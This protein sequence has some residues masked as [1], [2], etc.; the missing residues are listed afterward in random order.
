MEAHFAPW[1]STISC[2]ALCSKF[3][4]WVIIGLKLE[5]QRE[6]LVILIQEHLINRET[7]WIELHKNNYGLFFILRPEEHFWLSPKNHFLV[8]IDLF[9][10]VNIILKVGIAMCVQWGFWWSKISFLKIFQFAGS[11]FIIL[12]LP[13]GR[14]V[15]FIGWGVFTTTVFH[16]FSCLLFYYCRF[17]DNGTFEL[18]QELMQWWWARI[19]RDHFFKFWLKPG[20]QGPFFYLNH[21]NMI[22]ATEG[23]LERHYR[24]TS[25]SNTR[26]W[27][28]REH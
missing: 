5:S 26:E 19:V 6:L 20:A 1:A 28:Q 27:H 25:E 2:H 18:Q 7:F 13:L 10:S 23:R 21:Y 24:V 15:R 12:P 16:L 14:E 8:K 17:H 9:V 11:L 3:I 22:N 4:N